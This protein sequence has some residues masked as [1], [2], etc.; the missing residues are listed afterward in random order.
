M[1]MNTKCMRGMKHKYD[2]KGI[3]V[4]YETQAVKCPRKFVDKTSASE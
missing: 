1:S 2:E 3:N 4:L